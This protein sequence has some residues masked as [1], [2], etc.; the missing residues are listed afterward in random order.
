[1]E[2]EKLVEPFEVDSSLLIA[3]FDDVM[4]E[5]DKAYLVILSNRKG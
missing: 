2:H 1:M 3:E 4:H 5:L